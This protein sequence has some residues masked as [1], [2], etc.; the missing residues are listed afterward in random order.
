MRPS[1]VEIPHA[2]RT[3]TSS[4]PSL[5]LPRFIEGFLLPR[6]IAPFDDAAGDSF[7]SRHVSVGPL[8]FDLS[9]SVLTSPR[10]LV[11]CGLPLAWRSDLAQI[12]HIQHGGSPVDVSG[13]PPS[14]VRGGSVPTFV[15]ARCLHDR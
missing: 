4:T 9:N 2:K 14:L 8:P 13:K 11:T 5:A 7:R 3:R 6:H 10:S 12:F 15:H 1:A